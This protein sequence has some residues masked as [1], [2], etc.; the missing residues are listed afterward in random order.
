MEL[1]VDDATRTGGQGAQ[2]RAKPL[3]DHEEIRRIASAHRDSVQRDWARAG[4]IDLHWQ[5]PRKHSYVLGSEIDGS[6]GR[7]QQVGDNL[8]GAK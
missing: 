3:R 5:H 1:N 4:V 6:R 2:A 7:R 8:S